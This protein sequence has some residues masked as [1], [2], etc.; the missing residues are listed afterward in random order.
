MCAVAARF[1]CRHTFGGAQFFISDSG[2]GD[3]EMLTRNGEILCASHTLFT[4]G[5]FETAPALSTH[6][7]TVNGKIRASSQQWLPSNTTRYVSVWYTNS[8]MFQTLRY[9][10]KDS[11]T[12]L[13]RFYYTTFLISYSNWPLVYVHIACEIFS[14]QVTVCFSTSAAFRGCTHGTIVLQ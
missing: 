8:D 5:N 11:F 14:V 6:L 2:A 7:I 4:D 13:L 1:N 9:F 10:T 12:F 3:T